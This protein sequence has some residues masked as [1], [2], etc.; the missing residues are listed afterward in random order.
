MRIVCQMCGKTGHITLHCYHCFDV[1][2]IWNTKLPL[3]LNNNN[4]QAELSKNKKNNIAFFMTLTLT[5]VSIALKEYQQENLSSLTSSSILVGVSGAQKE[6]KRKM[7]EG[8]V[9]GGH[10]S[11]F[12]Q[13]L[14]C[15][16]RGYE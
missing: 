5:N 8:S 7:K 1:T 12:S 2:Y 6:S 10:A 15:Y 14:Y 9:V 3:D 4:S 11:I 13:V 16:T